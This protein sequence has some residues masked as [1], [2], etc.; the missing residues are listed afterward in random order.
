MRTLNL[1]ISAF[2]IRQQDTFCLQNRSV[3]NIAFQ[4]CEFLGSLLLKTETRTIRYTN[5]LCRNL[6][7]ATNSK[8]KTIT[9]QLSYINIL[10]CVDICWKT[11]QTVVIC[12]KIENGY[13][14]PMTFSALGG[15][16]APNPSQRTRLCAVASRIVQEVCRES[17]ALVISMMWACPYAHALL[18][19]VLVLMCSMNGHLYLAVS[20]KV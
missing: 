15:A 11:K 19:H 14:F 2:L 16:I 4:I 1:R 7:D 8:S 17:M 5:T 20:H 12:N 3:M 13:D 9:V 18:H 10:F 6:R